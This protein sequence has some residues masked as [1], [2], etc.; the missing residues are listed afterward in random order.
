MFPGGA[1]LIPSLKDFDWLFDHYL[2]WAVTFDKTVNRLKRQANS[3]EFDEKASRTDQKSWA[4]LARTQSRMSNPD[5]IQWIMKNADDF[6]PFISSV[7]GKV[8]ITL[9]EYKQK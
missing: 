4:E 6:G 8:T 2:D 7:G 5:R 1:A 3:K 9:S